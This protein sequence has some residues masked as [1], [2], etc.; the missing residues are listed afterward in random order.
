MIWNKIKKQTKID[1]DWEMGITADIYVII[2]KK[3]KLFK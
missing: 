2:A 1:D 3:Y